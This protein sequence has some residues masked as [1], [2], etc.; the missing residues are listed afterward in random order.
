MLV[1]TAARKCNMR[2]CRTKEL[3]RL[4]PI[5]IHARVQC[6]VHGGMPIRAM[7]DMRYPMTQLNQAS[8]SI[9]TNCKPF[10]CQRLL[11][12]VLV[13][14]Q[15]KPSHS[16]MSYNVQCTRVVYTTTNRF[17]AIRQTNQASVPYMTLAQTHTHCTHLFTFMQL[18]DQVGS[19]FLVVSELA[20][21]GGPP[22]MP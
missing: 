10:T 9:T 1:Q 2:R 5:G 15:H 14:P 3:A 13:S 12:Y 20:D 16:F 8:H 22:D 21:L 6:Q 17:T 18:A 7:E 19:R 11:L 4:Q